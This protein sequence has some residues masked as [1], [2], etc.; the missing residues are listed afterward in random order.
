ME[1][2]RT[3]AKGYDCYAP[4]R[5]PDQTAPT[6]L[7][8]RSLDGKD[9]RRRRNPKG[10]TKV[11]ANFNATDGFLRSR[12]APKLIET[13]YITGC[14]MLLNAKGDFSSS[15]AQLQRDYGIKAS[16]PRSLEF[17]YEIAYQLADVRG[18]LG[19]SP[20]PDFRDIR[21]VEHQESIF[22]A[23]KDTYCVGMVLYYIPI[24]PLYEMMHSDCRKKSCEL[25]LS[26]YAY[27]YRIVGIPSYTDN[28]SYLYSTYEWIGERDFSED[29]EG[30]DPDYMY[31]AQV[32]QV[33][34]MGS[35]LQL[36]L[37][38]PNH[39][40]QFETRLRKFSPADDL[41][42]Q[43]LE[44]AEKFWRLY[45]DHPTASIFRNITDDTDTDDDGQDSI[46]R[47]EQYLSFCASTEGDLFD[48]LFNDVNMEL[49]ELARMQE[50][51]VFVPIDGRKIE[52]NELDFE[53]TLFD[54]IEEL[55]CI[56]EPKN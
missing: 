36:E 52:G 35:I 27:L 50:P 11:R 31:E 34:E 28:G 2:G 41:D 1:H 38:D 23:H 33:M 47:L 10:Q 22:F 45:R 40:A 53:R 4:E 14:R 24:Q 3:D 20:L 8:V 30:S 49:Q 48:Q 7:Q 12:F 51:T 13:E 42:R 56:I 15:L 25:M 6:A 18:Q 5:R 54:L 17:P 44:I 55:V 46:V 19:E 37:Q 39:L 32:D 26:V 16:S 29:I 21:L 9:K 43:Y